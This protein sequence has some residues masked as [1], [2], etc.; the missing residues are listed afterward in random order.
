MMEVEIR[1]KKYRLKIK[2]IKGFW[3]GKYIAEVRM[4]I[5]RDNFKGFKEQ[6]SWWGLLG[7]YS[8]DVE[9]GRVGPVKTYYRWDYYLPFGSYDEQIREAW[10]KANEI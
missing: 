9:T 6:K 5:E 3:S 4:F 1:K 8:F 2:F 7:A 10:R